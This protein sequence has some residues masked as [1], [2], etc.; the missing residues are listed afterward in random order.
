MIKCDKCGRF[1]ST[2]DIAMGYATHIM[3]TPDSEHSYE[4]WESICPTCK[5]K[6]AFNRL[7]PE[8]KKILR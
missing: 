4:E 7:A 1:I 5:N 8:Q 6:E 2:Q 3:V